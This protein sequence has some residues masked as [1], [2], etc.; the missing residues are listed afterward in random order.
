M[1]S[2]IIAIVAVVAA[3]VLATSAYADH[4][5]LKIFGTGDVTVSGGSYRILNGSGEYGG[6]YIKGKSR[7][8][9]GK[10]LKKVHLSFVSSGD[11][12]GGAPRWSIPI[13]TDNDKTT[14]EGYAFI[15]AAGCGATVGD[16]PTGVQTTVSTSNPNCKV[17]FGAGVW[18]NWAA[19][20]A[21]N[22][23]Y[24]LPKESLFVIADLPG[25][26]TVSRVSFS[27]K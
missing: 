15:D 19:F 8:W 24:K 21:A 25:D 2:G 10:K 4:S 27:F 5:E 9:S 22:P 20:A 17:F 12:Q 18:A 7:V 14:A 26:Y 23:S 6:V 3:A 1:K 13:D 11:V 16:N